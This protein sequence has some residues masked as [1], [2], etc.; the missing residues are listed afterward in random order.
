MARHHQ[1]G[2]IM[3][4][5][6]AEQVYSPIVELRQYTLHPGQR[7]KEIALFEHSFIAAQEAVGIAVLGQFRDMQD[8]DRFVWLRGFL[9][10]DQR[11][12]ALQAF[13][14]GAVWREHRDEVNAMII[15]SDNVLLLR[16]A[17]PTWGFHLDPLGRPPVGD[18]GGR[19][20]LVMAAI[21]SFETAPSAD[22]LDWFERTLTPVMIKNGA[23]LLA[24]FV[25]EA[26]A[27]TFPIL[28][29]REGEQA[30]VWFTGVQNDAAFDQ[31][32]TALALSDRAQSDVVAN[33]APSQ[34]RSSDID[35]RADGALTGTR[36]IS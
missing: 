7:E 2:T 11:L 23:S 6:K 28:P 32:I 19:P 5:A 21:L 1:K 24:T 8:P 33:R 18:G 36:V 9:D 26:G 12:T 25:T 16:P 3:A 20:G 30:L 27:N 15:D 34:S 10:M 29:V 14:G 17:R 31:H 22:V 35:T 13:Y 4:N